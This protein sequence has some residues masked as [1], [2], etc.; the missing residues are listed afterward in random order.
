MF[1]FKQ[2]RDCGLE[3]RAKTE[4]DRAAAASTNFPR[5]GNFEYYLI[6]T[7]MGKDLNQAI[8]NLNPLLLEKA[9]YMQPGTKYGCNTEKRGTELLLAC[10]YF[11]A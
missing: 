7:S 1:R 2:V 3:N 5:T 10:L 6:K 9:E 4:F 11:T 8:E